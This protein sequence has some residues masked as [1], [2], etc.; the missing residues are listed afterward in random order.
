[1][2]NN[3][4][5]YNEQENAPPAGADNGLDPRRLLSFLLRHWKV[6]AASTVLGGVLAIIWVLQVVPLYTATAT[7]QIDVRR[8][9]IMRSEFVVSDQ[10]EDTGT[11]ATELALMQSFAVARRVVERLDLLHDPDFNAAPSNRG[12]ASQ[13][14]SMLGLENDVPLSQPRDTRTQDV[15]TESARLLGAIGAVQ[16]GTQAQR[17]GATWL[18][19]ISFTHHDPKVATRLANAIAETYIQDK[20]D[21]HHAATKRASAWLSERVDLLRQQVEA[22]ERA[23]TEQRAKYNLTFPQGVDRNDAKSQ[24]IAGT[25]EEAIIRLRDLE[26]Q[27]QADKALYESLLGRLK[28][29]EQ[30]ISL[31]F[32]ETRV[33]APALEPG[34]PSFPDKKR[35]ILIALLGGISAG[36][37]LAFLLERMERG[38][39]TPEQLEAALRHPVLATIPSLTARE[40][41]SGQAVLSFAEYL[42]QRPLSH[43]SESLRSIR[44]NVELA[45]PDDFPRLLMVTSSIPSEG[46]S[47]IAQ[48]L[49]QSAASAGKKILLID[50]DFRRPS[51]SSN[52]GMSGEPGLTD[53]LMDDKP[54]NEACFKE[55]FPNMSFLAAGTVTG[56][57]PDFIGSERLRRLLQKL[58][59]GY[60]LIV[61]DTPPVAPVA[62]SIQLS[63]LADKV[64]FVVAWRNAPRSVVERVVSILD[65]ADRKIVGIVFNNVVLEKAQALLDPYQ[66]GYNGHNSYYR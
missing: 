48:C 18:I 9:N 4:E 55:I 53:M 2:G 57:P 54:G 10:V 36:I 47:T 3:W 39:S 1:M 22:S 43:F 66:Y 29:A 19:A 13:I 50:C 11:I 24:G 41:Q 44:L 12:L 49:A 30:Q 33:I 46:K 27:S 42:L 23:V 51:L 38:F 59:A 65:K 63:R 62:D 5:A 6:I 17:L 26:R 60:D 45:D 58:R 35:N 14:K 28:E 56:H 61:L 8:Q 40:R 25:K 7:L 32:A 20:L 52:L 64:V 16:A 37:G 21:A 34:T 31:P 15:A